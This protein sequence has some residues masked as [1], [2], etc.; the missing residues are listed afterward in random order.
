MIT[1]EQKEAIVKW[2]RD[3]GNTHFNLRLEK[4]MLNEELKEFTDGLFDGEDVVEMM[5]AYCDT[6]FVLYGSIYKS[7]QT[8]GFE[9]A[10]IKYYIDAAKWMKKMLNRYIPNCNN[11]IIS[12]CMD[13]VIEANEAKPKDKVNGKVIKGD[14]WVDPKHKIKEIL[15]R[16]TQ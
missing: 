10:E 8:L 4:D 5:D 1:S 11:N 6:L 9:H 12:E 16:I 14:K 7:N 2:N 15:E 3:R 13:A